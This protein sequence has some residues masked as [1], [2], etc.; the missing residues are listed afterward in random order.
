MAQNFKIIKHPV[1][2]GA[3]V[4]GMPTVNAYVTNE[5]PEYSVADAGK[6][7]TVDANGELE[8][9]QGGGGGG[10]TIIMYA[11][12]TDIQASIADPTH[13]FQLYTDIGLSQGYTVPFLIPEDGYFVCQSIDS[14]H[15]SYTIY[16]VYY[17]YSEVE[18]IAA[19]ENANHVFITG[20][21]I[22]SQ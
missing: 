16:P 7:L 13:H 10:N 11:R 9:A 4:S 21:L 19:D 8:F 14:G 15:I 6:T 12:E 5:L 2:A 17:G 22:L 18:Y 20:D 1:A 3:A